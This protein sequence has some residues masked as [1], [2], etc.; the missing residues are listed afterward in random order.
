MLTTSHDQQ[1]YVDEGSSPWKK[2]IV[3]DVGTSLFVPSLISTGI[4][5]VCHQHVSEL[6]I[7]FEVENCKLFPQFG[8]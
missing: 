8:E 5:K 7:I 2:V 4:L 6:S 1:Y 3:D